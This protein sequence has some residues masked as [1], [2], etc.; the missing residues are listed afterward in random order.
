MW[1]IY[2]KLR[3]LFSRCAIVF[4]TAV[5]FFLFLLEKVEYLKMPRLRG[6]VN[7]NLASPRSLRFG[8]GVVINSGRKRN[9]VGLGIQT[10]L[11][12]IERGQITVGNRVGMSNVALI[13]R[14]S[15]TIE[16]DV[17]LGS[18][19]VVYDNDFHSLNAEIRC[20]GKDDDIKTAPVLI[21]EC[22]FIGAGS[23]ILKGVTI[24]RNSIIG[25]GSVV[26]RSVPDNEIWGGNPAKFIKKL[27]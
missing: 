19:V 8:K 27:V 1:R 14:E 3:K 7:V 15:I 6:F 13:A 11:M 5:G 26:T 17:L 4:T 16:D 12:T 20:H 22:A 25:A 24:G 23:I 21:K 9:P 2:K 10:S 18:G